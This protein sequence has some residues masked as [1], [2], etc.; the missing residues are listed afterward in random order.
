MCFV[1]QLRETEEKVRD[2]GQLTTV[3]IKNNVWKS[4]RATYTDLAK[5]NV[6]LSREKG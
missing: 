5:K 1:V 6:L 3:E 4:F 2:P